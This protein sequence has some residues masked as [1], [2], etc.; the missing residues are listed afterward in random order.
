M[1]RLVL[2]PATVVIVLE[3]STLR[4]RLSPEFPKFPLPATVVMVP[5]VWPNADAAISV[6][7]A[8]QHRET[9]NAL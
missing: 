2:L 1:P 5:G 7:A 9:L 6:I 3:L 8:W 4:T